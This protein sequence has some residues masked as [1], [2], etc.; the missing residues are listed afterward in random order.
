MR[1]KRIFAA[2]MSFAMLLSMTACN[3]TQTDKQ[4]DTGVP[5]T[6]QAAVRLPGLLKRNCTG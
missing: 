3:V 2:L 4:K 1:L 5:A 6:T